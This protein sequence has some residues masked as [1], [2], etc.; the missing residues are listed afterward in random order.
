LFERNDR[1]L[2]VG[3]VLVGIICFVSASGW[4]TLV[5]ADPAGPGAIPKILSV[6]FIV[7]GAIL[8]AGSLF[9]TKKDAETKALV[10]VNSLKITALLTA[11]CIAYLMILPYIGYLFAT[12]MLIGGIMFATGARKPKT[13]ILV[14]VLMTLIMFCIFYY[15]LRVNLPLGFMRSFMRALGLGR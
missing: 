1:Y 7:I 2:G 5:S 13:L 12:P 15:V 8:V 9:L 4:R 3:I 6:F 11:I 10:D 14:S